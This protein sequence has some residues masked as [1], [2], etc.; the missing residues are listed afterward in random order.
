[1]VLL[2]GMDSSGSL[3]ALNKVDEADLDKGAP[4]DCHPVTKGNYL[5]KVVT[6][7]LHAP[8]KVPIIAST[9]L[10]NM[11]VAKKQRESTC[12]RG[13]TRDGNEPDA[14]KGSS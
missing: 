1:V 14:S 6:T 4:V 5:R 3:T 9:K 11:E 2:C 12:L 13:P 10:P 7:A 8:F